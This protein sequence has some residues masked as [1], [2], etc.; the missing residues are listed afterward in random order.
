[1]SGNY[2]VT[3]EPQASANPR[4]RS[5]RRQRG[6]SLDLASFDSDRQ[7]H[8][9]SAAPPRPLHPTG[10][11][12]RLLSAAHLDGPADSTLDLSAACRSLQLL[13]AGR[14]PARRWPRVTPSRQQH[15]LVKLVHH[16][17]VNRGLARGGEKGIGCVFHRLRMLD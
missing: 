6:P 13:Q 16:L 5:G 12:L 15:L 3:G 10:V 8:A 14:H 11:P 4:P 2:L 17:A 7:I 9:D 1:M